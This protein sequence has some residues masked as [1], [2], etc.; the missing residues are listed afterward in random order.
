MVCLQAF[1]KRASLLVYGVFWLVFRPLLDVLL[2]LL[3]RHPLPGSG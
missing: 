2:A 3:E 1:A